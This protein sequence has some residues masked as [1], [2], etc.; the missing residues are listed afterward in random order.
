MFILYVDESGDTGLTNSP[1][2]HFVLSGLVVH[3]LRWRPTLDSIVQFRRQLKASY[4]LKMSD[5]IHAKDFLHSPGQ[6]ARIQKHSRLLILKRV[7]E[8]QGTRPDISIIN[9]VV[10]KSGKPVDYDVFEAAWKTLLQRFHN[11]IQYR[12]FPG[13]QNAEDK[14]LVIT[15]ATD[16]VKLRG[17]LRKMRH[18]NPIPHHPNF[19]GHGTRQIPLDLI[20]EDPIHRDSA[21]S[22]FIQMCDVNAFALYQKHSPSSYVRKKGGAKWFDLLDLALC[23]RAARNDPQGIV[24][25]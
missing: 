23:K 16:G 19:P 9:V 8:F 18:Y 15:D 21:H 4:G 22:Y 7:L 25:I 13:P 20:V 24:R 14:G 17:L 6:L 5:E 10:D 12:N 3:E 1:T 2:R 11:T